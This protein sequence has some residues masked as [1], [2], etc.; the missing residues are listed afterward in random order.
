MEYNII[1]NDTDIHNVI[2]ENNKNYRTINKFNKFPIDKNR[3][4][5]NYD[6]DLQRINNNCWASCN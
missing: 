1:N 3:V 6:D 4:H 5:T 2:E